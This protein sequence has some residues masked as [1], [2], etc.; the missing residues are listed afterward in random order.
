M[1]L[2]LNH[3]LLFFVSTKSLA[4]CPLNSETGAYENCGNTVYGMQPSSMLALMAI[5]GGVATSLF[6]PW[7]G[8]VVDFS[9]HRLRF[10]KAMAIVLTLVNFVQIFIYPS[11]WFAMTI[12]QAVVASASFMA[13]SMVMWSYVDADNDRDLHGITSSGRIWEVLGVLF[14]FIVVGII[15][16]I[17]QWDEV[18]IARFSQALASLVGGVSLLLAY[19]RYEPVK[20]VKKLE[21][22]KNLYVAGVAQL[23]GTITDLGKTGPGAQR[24]LIASTFLEAA[25]NS[26]T[27]IC[28]TY[29]TEQIQMNGMQVII[30]ILIHSVSNP[31]GVLMHRRIAGRIGNKRSYLLATVWFIII[32]GL[33]IG[34]VSGP[35]HVTITYVF[36]VLFGI[37]YG[38][39]YPSSNGFYIV[40]VPRERV[41][42][43]WGFNMF[44]AAIL[45]WVPPLIFTSL[46]ESTGNLRLGFLGMTAFQVI[47]LLIGMAIPNKTKDTAQDDD[48]EK[49][50]SVEVIEV[51][52]A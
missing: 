15:Q 11:T 40:L 43:L 39:Y 48:A 19:K 21:S 24:Y 16:F 51:V 28:I 6:M 2:C 50:N 36:S 35:H 41:A 26:F 37:A 20:A 29:L 33:F 7:A 14:V 52:V 25:V 9:D 34:F 49:G 32:T 47:G 30:F 31:L 23:L 42:E 18:T 3:L 4:G 45:S 27:T 22:G 13:N 5:I 8:A 46:N 44:A 12:L 1:M 10:G 17:T 38:W